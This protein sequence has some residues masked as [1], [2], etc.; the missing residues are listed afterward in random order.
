MTVERRSLEADYAS[1]SKA[2]QDPRDWFQ[3]SLANIIST[4]MGDAA[5]TN[6]RPFIHHVD[7]SD[8]CRVQATLCP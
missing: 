8:I 3:Q 5:P 6:V 4:A 2:D 7:G 1:R